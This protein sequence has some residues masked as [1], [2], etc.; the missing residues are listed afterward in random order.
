MIRYGLHLYTYERQISDRTWDLLP[1][2]KSFGYQGC[3]V[4][5]MPV[6][7]DQFDSTLARDKLQ[8]YGMGAVGSTGMTPD[9]CIA[10]DD[11]QV[12]EKGMMHMKHATDLTAALGASV[13]S[14]ALYAAFGWRP[15]AGRT[16]QQWRQSVS[17]LREL[18]RYASDHG[19][20]LAIEPLNRYEHYF[21]NTVEQAVV[22]ANEVGEPNLKVHVDTYH[23]NIEEKDLYAAIVSAGSLLGHVHC[24]ENDRGIPGTGHI[25][26]Q[27]LFRG[28]CD[29]R[30]KGWIVV[31]SFF[32]PIPSIVDFSPIWR[33]LAKDA[34]TLAVDS[35]RFLRKGLGCLEA[36]HAVG[37]KKE[38]TGD[39][40]RKAKT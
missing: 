7:M 6:E 9:M 1:R 15:P 23:M 38:T 14:G 17:S 30:Y 4:P 18:A 26:W 28:L 8:E 37:R 21:L 5:L 33:R 39:G 11:H 32:E 3:E 12:R 34:D 24:S 2:L 10:S 36:A 16:R 25:D 40:K 29:L 19:V 22:L 35:L 27:G 20:T 31:E 13:L